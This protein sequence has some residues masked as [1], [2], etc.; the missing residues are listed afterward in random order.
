MSARLK[1][2]RRSV[3]AGASASL[4]MLAPGLRVSFAADAQAGGDILVVLCMR[5]GQDGL[6]VL[7]P[8]G[9]P[10]YIA[11]RP[12]MLVPASAASGAGTLDGTDFY[13]HPNL[14]G[15]KQLYDAGKLAAVQAV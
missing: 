3:L 8:A 9:D 11:H 13:F 15:L 6:Q 14:M 7:A 1:T 2:S 5:G 4:A 10:Q 12:S